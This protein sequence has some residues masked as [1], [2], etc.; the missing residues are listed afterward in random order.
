MSFQ[1]VWYVR[2]G[3]QVLGPFP[4]RMISRGVLLGRFS[5]GDQVSLDKAI[6]LRLSEVAELL[7]QP[8]A[9][10]VQG[11]AKSARWNE[12]RRLAELRWADE[13][14]QPDRR[15]EQADATRAI[16]VAEDAR[17]KRDRRLVKEAPAV[18]ANREAHVPQASPIQGKRTYGSVLTLIGLS[19]AVIA[20]A[21]WLPPV[22]PIKVGLGPATPTCQAPPVASINW[23]G[24]NRSGAWL[25]G[26]VLQ[27][28]NLSNGRLSNAHL[29]DSNLSYANLSGAD[30]VNAKLKRARLLGAKL[31]NAKLNNADLT[32]ADL[33]YADLRSA[34][35]EGAVLTGA[36]LDNAIWPDGNT[37]AAGS[38]GQCLKAR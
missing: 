16:N 7:P 4:E 35:I 24:C 15:Q 34:V 1:A 5:R 3:D 19:A 2:H 32:E 6:W 37:C 12:E 17:S 9:E 20:G 25:P 23:S 31:V 29:N 33:S 28:A 26:V 18:V 13:R 8:A 30:L 11:K 36:H 38:L 21:L 14:G 22:E 27:S 10:S